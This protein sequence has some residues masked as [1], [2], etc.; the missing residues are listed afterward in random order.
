MTPLV[1]RSV[2][3]PYGARLSFRYYGADVGLEVLWHGKGPPS[4]RANK[5]KRRFLEAYRAARM[6]FAEEVVAT[7]GERIA[8]LD[9]GTGEIECPR[10]ATR[11]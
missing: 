9:T 11:H 3:L 10:P 4:I 8:F 2:A 5:A 6:R 1:E 7:T